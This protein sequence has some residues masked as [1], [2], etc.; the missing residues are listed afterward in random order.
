MITRS[1]W[2]LVL[3]LTAL[4][5][6]GGFLGATL[7]PVTYQAEAFVVVYSMPPGFNNLISPDEA[8]TINAFY[9]AGALQDQ[10]VQRVRQRYPSLS[11]SLIRQ[12]VQVSIVAYT[13]LTRVTATAGSATAA[14][15][16]A[17]A[18]ASAW[19]NISGAVL[20]QAYESTYA[21]LLSHEQDITAQITATQAQLDLAKPSSTKAQQLSDQLQTLRTTFA[22]AD[23]NLT[24]LEKERYSVAGNAYIATPASADNATRAP[25]VSKSL[26]TGGAI[27]LGV[28]AIAAL[29]MLRGRAPALPEQAFESIDA[30][31]PVTGDDALET[32][33]AG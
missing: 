15:A 21:G 13:P 5:C 30:A 16:L 12:A 14:A 27:G 33:H 32:H 18:V 22:T 19:V 10:V 4:G 8:N 28:G 3:A 6:L 7:Q 26:T 31:S 9:T 17:N 1:I 23:A 11:A 29:W 20:T 2:L 25:D 24:A